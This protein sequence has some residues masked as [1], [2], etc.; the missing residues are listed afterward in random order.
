M[1]LSFYI[2]IPYC[3][4]RCGY[5]DFNTYTPGEL[6]PGSDIAQ[7]S[8]GYI[9]LLIQEGKIARSEVKTTKPIETIFFGGGTPTLNGTGRSW[10]SA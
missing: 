10:S 3:V 6:K 1:P 8:N 7:V 2:H 9:D 5:C 4:K